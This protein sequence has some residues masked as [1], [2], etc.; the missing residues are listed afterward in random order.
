MK[1]QARK[2]NK[3]QE[4]QPNPQR[5]H[6]KVL[7]QSGGHTRDF[8]VHHVAVEAAG[9]G[10]RGGGRARR[11][12]AARVAGAVGNS[13]SASRTESLGLVGGHVILVGFALEVAHPAHFDGH[14]FHVVQGNDLL[15]WGEASGKNLGDAAFNV[16]HDVLVATNT[17]KVGF[18]LGQVAAEYVVP[19][20]FDVEDEAL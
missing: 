5:V 15:G 10:G 17:G 20:F 7:G 9:A 8:A 13:G 11:G 16:G 3:S 2:E 12:G 1:H 19:I 4:A 14:C 6:H 18:H